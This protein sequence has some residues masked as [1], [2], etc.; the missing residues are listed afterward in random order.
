MWYESKAK[1]E[2]VQEDG[3]TKMVTESYMVDAFT[4]TEA[5][6]RTMEEVAQ[7]VSGEL[8]VVALKRTNIKE[9]L[10]NADGDKWYNCKLVFITLDEKSGK[11]KK[12]SYNVLVQASSIEDGKKQ[13]ELLMQG[14][15]QDWELK[16]I[17]ETN[18]MDVYAHGGATQA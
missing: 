5:E 2:Q 11:E 12:T 16:S 15:M 18:I 4:F 14:S 3:C 17:T 9:V 6:T 8:D 7:Y 13:V 10:Y 1:F